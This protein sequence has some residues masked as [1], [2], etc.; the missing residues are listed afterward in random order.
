MHP[1][2]SPDDWW[3]AVLGSGY[4]GTVDALDAVDRESVRRQNLAFIRE[5]DIQAVEAN[6]VYAVATRQP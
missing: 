5:A 6:V 4:R 3:S 2:R 1:L